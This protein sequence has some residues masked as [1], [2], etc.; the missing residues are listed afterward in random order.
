MEVSNS[1]GSS[2]SSCNIVL[3]VELKMIIHF[4]EGNGLIKHVR[5]IIP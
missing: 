3:V 1:S 4:E 2:D 5:I